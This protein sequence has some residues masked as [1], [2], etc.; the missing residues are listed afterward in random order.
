MYAV[1]IRRY[2]SSCI[3]CIMVVSLVYYFLVNYFT[4]QIYT[5]YLVNVNCVTCELSAVTLDDVRLSEQVK[6]LVDGA[7]RWQR[8]TASGA[9]PH[10]RLVQLHVICSQ[11]QAGGLHKYPHLNAIKS[12]IKTTEFINMSGCLFSIIS[13]II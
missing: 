3:I 13:K 6:L 7:E 9:G 8:Q 5:G 11:P 10:A 1:H 2:A 12:T 4:S